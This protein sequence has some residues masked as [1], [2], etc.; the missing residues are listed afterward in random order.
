MAEEPV[1][2][3][4]LYYLEVKIHHEEKIADSG[5]SWRKIVMCGRFTLFSELTRL[6]E[7]FHLSNLK[8]VLYRPRYNIAPSQDVLCVINDGYKNRAGMIRWGLIPS[9]AKD[10]TTGYKMI[11]ARVETIDKK[12][13]F[14]RLLERRRCLILADSFFEWK[15]QGNKKIPMRIHL[16]DNQPFGMAGLWDHW[17]SGDGEKITSCTIITTNSNKMLKPIHN[18]MPVI[19]PEENEKA[20]LD[21]SIKDKGFLKSLLVP[22]D[23]E[24]MEVYEVSPA[25]NSPKNDSP[26]CIK[27]I[28][29]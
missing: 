27:E 29:N 7:R 20:W 22:Y 2:W 26:E 21:R 14:K 17:Q 11:N 4:L 1:L 19:L 8:N 10:K 25:V 13:T 3:V 6:M 12:P 16:K 23:T 9:F 28:N 18:R 24:Q 15:K 5:K